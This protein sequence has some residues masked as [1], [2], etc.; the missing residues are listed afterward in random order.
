MRNAIARPLVTSVLTCLV[1]LVAGSPCRAQSATTLDDAE[2]NKGVHAERGYFSPEPY[3]HFDTMS[4]NV[5]LT[6]TDL[7]LPGNAGRTLSFQRTYNNQSYQSGGFATGYQ[8]NSRWQFGFPGM[9]MRIF[10]RDIP[11]NP[12]LDTFA[13]ILQTTPS[14][15]MA[16]GSWRR[17]VYVENPSSVPDLSKAWVESEGFYRYDREHHVLHMPDGTVANYDFDAASPNKGR[18]LSFQD[19]FGN[20]V[21]LAWG[22]TEVVVTQH[23][24][25][26]NDRQIHLTLDPAG[27]VTGMQYQG[28]QWT[29]EYNYE[30]ESSKDIT[31]VVLPGGLEWGFTYDNHTRDQAILY[32][33]NGLTSITTPNQG[34]ILYA[35]VETEI[36]TLPIRNL[37]A[38][39]A[40]I[41][42]VG[43][44]RGRGARRPEAG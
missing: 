4:G 42:G 1:A 39:R 20:L 31:R 21:E 36:C 14:F 9:V 18:L 3:E 26:G 27:R 8:A 35:Y 28:R 19:Q 11:T 23:L 44:L 30:F 24:G 6:F 38:K 17:T 29:Y 16:D 33:W 12:N 43:L 10:E 5:V 34:S 15:I 32:E 40:G 7:V 25:N 41:S 2:N 37:C 13:S 22:A